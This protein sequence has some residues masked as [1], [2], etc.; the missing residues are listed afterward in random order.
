[1]PASTPIHSE[2]RFGHSELPSEFAHP[3]LIEAW[4]GV[5]FSALAN[6]SKIDAKEWRQ[7]NLTVVGNGHSL[8]AVSYAPTG[9]YKKSTAIRAVLD[10]VVKSIVFK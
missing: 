9:L 4:L 7:R 2:F 3:P 8:C 6:F 5:E 10:A 1:M